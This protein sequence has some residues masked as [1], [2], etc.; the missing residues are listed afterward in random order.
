MAF[1]PEN[2]DIRDSLP[3]KLVKHLKRKKINVIY[4]DDYY[5]HKDTCDKNYLINNSDIII[6]GTTHKNYKKLKFKK[7]QIIIDIGGFFEK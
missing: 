3:T 7:E 2:D 5:K 6:I 4:S 1:K